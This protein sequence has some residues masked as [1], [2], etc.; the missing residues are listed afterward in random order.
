MIG[1]SRVTSWRWLLPPARGLTPPAVV[2]V[3]ALRSRMA[4]YR[5]AVSL[6]LAFAHALLPEGRRL[7]LLIK[8][9]PGPLRITKCL[10]HVRIITALKYSSD[11]GDDWPLES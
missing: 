11:P 9:N 4:A 10:T 1:L 8:L 6:A 5:L 7:V 2:V 3:A